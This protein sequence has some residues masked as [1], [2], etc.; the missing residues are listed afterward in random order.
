MTKSEILFN[1]RQAIKQADRLEEIAKKVE[2]L[3]TNN[4]S[5][6]LGNLRMAWKSD[7]SSQYFNKMSKVQGDIKK[8]AQNLRKVAQSIRKTA[9]SV[10]T[11]ELR[12]LE[13]AKTRNYK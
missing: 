10:K 4:M 3:A 2:K 6:S 8:D 5:N 11:A 13:I 7:S 1:Y 12:A 9:E